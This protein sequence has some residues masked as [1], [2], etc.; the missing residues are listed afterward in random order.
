VYLPD[1]GKRR[2][3]VARSDRWNGGKVVDWGQRVWRE[4][5]HLFRVV[6]EY[7]KGRAPLQASETLLERL[8]VLHARHGNEY[9]VSRSEET[10][11]ERPE[12]GRHRRGRENH[13]MIR[14]FP[15]RIRTNGLLEHSVLHNTLRAKALQLERA[16]SVRTVS[17]RCGAETEAH[18]DS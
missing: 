15:K 6:N 5:T 3:R 11:C 16:E 10:N 9:D 2:V 14:L 1:D 17:E 7:T 12:D 8:G 18:C 13:Y 4:T